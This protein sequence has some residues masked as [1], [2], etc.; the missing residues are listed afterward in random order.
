M[1]FLALSSLAAFISAQEGGGETWRSLYGF[2]GLT[3]QVFFAQSYTEVS[4]MNV[5]ESNSILM[6]HEQC[7]VP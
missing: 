4:L 1:V 7:R 6:S 3:V 5:A 2:T